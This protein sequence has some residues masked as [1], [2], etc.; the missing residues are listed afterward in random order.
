MNRDPWKKWWAWY[1]VFLSDT[2]KWTCRKWV[3]YRPLGVTTSAYIVSEIWPPMYEY[4]SDPLYNMLEAIKG[5]E[6]FRLWRKAIAEKNWPSEKT[7]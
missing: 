6:E 2:G 7:Q 5:P 3:E 4:R 1:P